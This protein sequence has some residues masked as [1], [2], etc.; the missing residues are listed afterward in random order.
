[1]KSWVK[2]TAISVW[3]AGGGGRSLQCMSHDSMVPRHAQFR[4][5]WGGHSE[6][7]YPVL[8][9]DTGTKSCVP[10]SKCMYYLEG[11]LSWAGQGSLYLLAARYK[12]KKKFSLKRHSMIPPPQRSTDNSQNVCCL[13]DAA[14]GQAD[15]Y[16]ILWVAAT[17]DWKVSRRWEVP[18]EWAILT[19]LSS[20]FSSC[21]TAATGVR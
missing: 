1:M 17:I 7:L 14:W 5:M 20:S 6:I 9:N 4:R 16:L 10:S 18:G 13:L 21:I 2:V 8:W 15:L 12:K 11:V 3:Q 19:T